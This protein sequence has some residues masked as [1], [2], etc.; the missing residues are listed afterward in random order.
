VGLSKPRR[1]SGETRGV[2]LATAWVLPVPG[3]AI[4]VILF[5]VGGGG[6]D[7]L[8]LPYF[9]FLQSVMC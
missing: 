5:V 7:L 9:N 6:G 3:R 2:G 8:V 4:L 1:G